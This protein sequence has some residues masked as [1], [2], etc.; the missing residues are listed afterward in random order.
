MSSPRKGRQ[1]CLQLALHLSLLAR[2]CP[3]IT[4]TPKGICHESSSA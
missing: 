4:H 3:M 1:A 2:S